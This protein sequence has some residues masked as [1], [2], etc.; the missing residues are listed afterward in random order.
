MVLSDIGLIGQSEENGEK[1][2]QTT[3]IC[4]SCPLVAACTGKESVLK[5]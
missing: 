3:T 2:G 4:T 1:T 5:R